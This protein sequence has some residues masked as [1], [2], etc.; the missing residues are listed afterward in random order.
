MSVKILVLAQALWF[1]VGCA[2]RVAAG[3]P[4][5]LL[6]LHIVIP[7]ISAL[8]AY[9]FWTFKP[10]DVE[11]PIHLNIDIGFTVPETREY[12]KNFYFITE[13]ARPS[14]LTAIL[15][16]VSFTGEYM[17]NTQ[18]L[19]VVAVMIML[20]GAFH[21]SGYFVLFPSGMERNAWMVCSGLLCA[22]PFLIAFILLH[23]EYMEAYY[24]L[25]WRLRF[26]DQTSAFRHLF[27]IVW[28]SW[29]ETLRLCTGGKYSFSWSWLVMSIL[30]FSLMNLAFW[31]I[32][33]DCA[34]VF[35]IMVLS[36]TSLRRLAYGAYS[37][38][39][40]SNY[41]PQVS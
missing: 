34:C 6:E 27:E 9:Y 3:L 37:T 21:A 29:K 8:T 38:P 25:L 22:V 13:D 17:I 24:H 7:V 16:A 41:V 2:A 1:V 11:Q 10:L 31:L 12:P 20:N 14:I 4:I 40:W 28:K 23:S 18:H 35:G 15:R 26:T 30:R 19:Y 33:C 32:V 36:V 39:L 5:T